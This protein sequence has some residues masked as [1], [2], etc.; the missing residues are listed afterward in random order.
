M[1]NPKNGL[2]VLVLDLTSSILYHWP[3][4]QGSIDLGV[5]L[6]FHPLYLHLIDVTVINSDGKF[7]VDDGIYIPLF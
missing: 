4:P 3:W 5:D 6:E 2:M 1:R 7:I